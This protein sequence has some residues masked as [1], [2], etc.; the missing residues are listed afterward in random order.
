MVWSG[1]KAPESSNPELIALGQWVE[2]ELERM[3][4]E[5]IDNLQALD[6]RPTFNPPLRPREGMIVHADGTK[7]NPGFGAGPYYRSAAGLWVPMSGFTETLAA[8][9]EWYVD[10]ALGNDANDGLAAGSGRAFKTIGKAIT[11]TYGLF[12]NGFNV[13]INVADGTYAESVQ[14]PK[15]WLGVGTVT[16][17]GNTTTPANC[18]ISSAVAG[19]AVY[20]NGAALDIQGFRLI[21][22]ARFCL[23][24]EFGASVGIRGKM[25]F[26]AGSFG[27]IACV[28]NS[29]LLNFVAGAGAWNV[30]GGGGA[31]AIFLFCS[32]G[33]V[34]QHFA[35]AATVT[36]S[37]NV[38]FLATAYASNWG[39]IN[40]SGLTWN[41]GAFVV[42]AQRFNVNNFSIIATGGGG[43]NYFPG[44]V[45]GAGTVP[46]VAPWGLYT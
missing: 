23:E 25:D 12:L 22:A 39:F 40:S 36:Y 38:T 41:I 5:Q 30:S 33:G 32:S 15:P 8:T 6:L 18:I 46:N 26:G 24:M 2:D 4:N 17:K 34:F 14:C 31:G 10:T 11:K 7:W 27:T 16:L 28:S 19:S 44:T 21:S 1:N 35:A 29:Q 3:A 20:V 43:V 9:R 42:T 37:A 45:A 13:N